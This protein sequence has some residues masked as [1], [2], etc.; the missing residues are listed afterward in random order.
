MIARLTTHSP[1]FLVDSFLEHH[2]FVAGRQIE[3]SLVP[4][5]PPKLFGGKTNSPE[6]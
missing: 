1:L 2:Y 5:P 4:A 3:V 6:A